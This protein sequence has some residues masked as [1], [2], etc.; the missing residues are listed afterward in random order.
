MTV[1][2]TSLAWQKPG[3]LQVLL[4]WSIFVS[5]DGQNIFQNI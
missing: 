4:S 3:L 1:I 5:A 2:K